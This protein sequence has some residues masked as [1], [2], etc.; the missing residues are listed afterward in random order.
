MIVRHSPSATR[1]RLSSAFGPAPESLRQRVVDDDDR[2]GP[3]VVPV[4]E[5]A[6][7][8]ERDAQ[9]PEVVRARP[10]LDM[11]TRSSPRRC[12]SPSMLTRVER[13][14]RKPS[15]RVFSERRRFDAGVGARRVE[16]LA[17]EHAAARL[18]VPF[19]RTSTPTEAT[20]S[21]RS[22]GFSA[23]CGVEAPRH[24]PG[25]D[26]EQS[27]TATCATTRTAAHPSAGRAARR[28]VFVDEPSQIDA[29]ALQRRHEAED[30]R[31]AA[32]GRRRE[33]NHEAVDFDVEE[34]RCGAA[35]HSAL[36]MKSRDARYGPRS[37]TPRLAPGTA[38]TRFSTQQPNDPRPRRAERQAHGDLAASRT[39]DQHET[40]DVRARD[41]STSSPIALQHDHRRQHVAL[42]AGGR[43]PER[44]DSQPLH[45]SPTG[46]SRGQRGPDRVGLRDGIRLVMPGLR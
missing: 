23:P 21:A 35:S 39:R 20:W 29:R 12:S 24:Q 40:R 5:R 6:A 27:D 17:I 34:R 44:H 33:A 26:Q 31:T 43:L 19:W 42:A 18:V 37:S 41:R 32:G 4:L 3:F 7:G 22:R 38:R 9:R 11:K 46:R 36:P 13:V 15:G 28:G 8:D 25:A 10:A 45:G 30:E 14:S 1:I 2:C 16:Q